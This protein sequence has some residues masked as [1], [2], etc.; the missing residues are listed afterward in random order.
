MIQDPDI[1]HRLDRINLDLQ[2]QA[3]FL[4]GLLRSQGG[5][6][7]QAEQPVV[8]D[9]EGVGSVGSEQSKESDDDGCEVSDSSNEGMAS[10]T[11]TE[12]EF[13]Y[14]DD[15]DKCNR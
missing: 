12:E 11:R 4:N 5:E 8:D 2:I 10:A 15:D 13:A 9:S 6:S 7:P 3:D 1:I 14:D